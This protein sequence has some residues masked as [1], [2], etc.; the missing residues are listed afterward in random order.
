MPWMLHWK[1]TLA[2][3][4]AYAAIAAGAIIFIKDTVLANTILLIAFFII[5]LV[6]NVWIRNR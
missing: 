5:L 6:G 2:M 4:A 1:A 3:A